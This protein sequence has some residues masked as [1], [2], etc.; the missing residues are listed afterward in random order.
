MEFVATNDYD[1]WVICFE[2]YILY[3]RRGEFEIYGSDKIIGDET[4]HLIS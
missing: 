2:A 1:R 4:F 3:K